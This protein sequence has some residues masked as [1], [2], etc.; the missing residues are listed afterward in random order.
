[1]NNS[2]I[3]FLYETLQAN[4]DKICVADEHNTLTFS[5][6]FS[7]AYNISKILHKENTI[8]Q[9]VLVYLPK[10]LE[11]IVS[12][13]GILL[14]GNFYVPVDI[15]SP[16]K[17]IEKIIQNLAPYRIISTHTYKN[18]LRG[19]SIPKKKIVFLEDINTENNNSRAFNN[20]DIRL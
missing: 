13:A 11:A 18:Y 5:S 9:P 15:K 14:S 20:T 3:N 2:S 10:S 4:P 1:M 16:L 17:R 19:F 6:L 7:K 8:N 12:F